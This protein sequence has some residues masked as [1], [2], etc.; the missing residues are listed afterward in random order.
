MADYDATISSHY[1]KVAE[2]TGLSATSTMADDYIRTHESEAI[3]SFAQC[4]LEWRVFPSRSIQWPFH[5]GS[6]GC[7]V[8][9]SAGRAYASPFLGVDG[10]NP[11]PAS[12]ISLKL[13]SRG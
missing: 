9:P 13:S 12:A 8:F 3:V 2:A 10:K 11:G 7:Q 6:T 1:A 4:S 5:F